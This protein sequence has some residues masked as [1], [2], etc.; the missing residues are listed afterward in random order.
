MMSVPV[1][2]DGIRSGVNWMRLNFRSRTRASVAISSVLA[3]PG[4]PTI[5]LLPPTKS[6]PQ[7]ELDDSRSGD[8]PLLQLVDDLLPA[9]VHLVARAI[10]SADSKVAVCVSSTVLVLSVV[11]A[12]DDVV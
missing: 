10:M 3:R 7:H 2:S 8:N 11:H 6:G 12:V 4:T 9:R 5:R 1:M